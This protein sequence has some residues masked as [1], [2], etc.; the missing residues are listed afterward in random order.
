[1]ATPAKGKAAARSKTKEPQQQPAAEDKPPMAA[2]ATPKPPKGKGA[3]HQV[4]TKAVTGSKAAVG[5]AGDDAPVLQQVSSGV[6]AAAA[7]TEDAAATSKASG[8]R[9]RAG[10]KAAPSPRKETRGKGATALTDAPKGRT[11]PE[12][13]PKMESKD[14]QQLS[15]A[16]QLAFSGVSQCRSA[17]RPG[18]CVALLAGTL[19]Y[20]NQRTC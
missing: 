4:T 5:K 14:E 3:G 11:L 9:S 12:M 20:L 6:G 13:P 19:M 17:S 8:N 15:G 18:L 10:S 16:G 7:A 1:V 2:A